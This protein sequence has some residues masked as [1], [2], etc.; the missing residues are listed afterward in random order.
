MGS[1]RDEVC[2]Y[3]FVGNILFIFFHISSNVSRF[4]KLR[5]KIM[6]FG[7]HIDKKLS[8]SS[9]GRYLK[10]HIATNGVLG[11]QSVMVC[12]HL[13]SALPRG[14]ILD[15]IKITTSGLLS[16]EAFTKLL[17]LVNNNESANS[18][19]TLNIDDFSILIANPSVNQSVS[20]PTNIAWGLFLLS[21]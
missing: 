1:M 9:C 14:L 10:G 20:L 18:I 13:R 17:F 11:Q 4:V 16:F 19:F 6:L 8:I 15:N 3:L 21:L 5:R 2:S 12:K 7:G